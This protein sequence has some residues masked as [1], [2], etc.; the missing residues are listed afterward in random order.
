MHRLRKS[1]SIKSNKATTTNYLL[2]V[3]NNLT[4]YKFCEQKQLDAVSKHPGT[5]NQTPTSVFI[6]QTSD[7]TENKGEQQILQVDS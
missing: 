3:K 5:V 7:I 6:L 4:R 1:D 2:R